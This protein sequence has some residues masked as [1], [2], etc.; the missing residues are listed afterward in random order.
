MLPLFDRRLLV[1]TGKGGTGKT[2]VVAALSQ[3]AAARGLRTLAIETGRSARIPRLFGHAAAEPGS[4]PQRLAPRLETLRI[5]PHAALREYLQ[6]TLPAAGWVGRILDVPGFRTWLD[7]VPGWR[8]LITLGKVWHLA[9]QT[10]GTGPRYELLV[11]DAPATGHGLTFLD[12][13]SVT[14]SA[15]RAGPLRRHASAVEEMLRDPEHTL[16]VPV[17]LPEE[18]PT[19]ETLELV[20]RL[21]DDLGVSVDRILVNALEADPLAAWPGLEDALARSDDAAARCTAACAAHFRIRHAL[22]SH[23]VERLAEHAGLPLTPL[24]RLAGGVS[25][26]ADLATLGRAVLDAEAAA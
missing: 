21:R 26:A 2:T 23:Q 8:E 20:A 1:V 9:Q 6:L 18:T 25:D 3:A 19:S 5:E 24:P 16:I 11:V 13:P 4:A 22:Q 17:T 7:A 15:V 12:V 14:V 10:I